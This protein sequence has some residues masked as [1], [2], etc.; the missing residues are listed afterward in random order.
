[1]IRDWETWMLPDLIQIWETC[2]GDEEAYIRFFLER[3]LPSGLGLVWVEN[4]RAL[5]AFYL[6][7]CCIGAAPA[8]YGYA[9]GVVPSC[10]GRGIGGRLLEES[11]RRGKA[12]GRLFFVAPRLGTEEYYAGFGSRP[13]FYYRTSCHKL[14][15]PAAAAAGF[16]EAEIV[17]AGPERYRELRD[18]ALR[19]SGDVRWDTG[20]VEYALAEQ[21]LCG[22]FAHIL[23][24]EGSSYLL[25]GVRRDR[26]L[27]LRETTLPEKL[28]DALL[29]ALCA[30]YRVDTVHCERCA[31]TAQ[32]IPRGCVWGTPP[33]R[34]GWLGLDLV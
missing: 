13:A 26:A 28:P 1:M 17:Q 18:R 31:G 29:G 22:G 7:P 3:R 32:G 19:G 25:F 33:S 11:I 4:G 12:D 24:W 34:Q 15:R 8:L 20:A 23:H 5:G 9:L 16:P 30:H 6:L 21:R 14:P 27:F 2:F 10:R